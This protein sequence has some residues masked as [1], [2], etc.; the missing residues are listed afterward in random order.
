L[1]LSA[2]APLYLRDCWVCPQVRV[3]KRDIGKWP[4]AGP[5]LWEPD[6]E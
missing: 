5:I 2:C 3:V 4:D 1:I 6:S